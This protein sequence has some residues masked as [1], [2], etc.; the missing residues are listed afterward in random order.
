MSL[1]DEVKTNL[2]DLYNVTSHKTV[3]V[4]R[5]SSRKYEK[6]GISR[7]IE[8]QFSELGSLVFNSVQE[9]RSEEIAG[10]EQILALV[11]RIAVLEKELKE[12]DEEIDNIRQEATRPPRE[13]AAAAGSAEDFSAENDG[14]PETAGSVDTII[15]DPILQEGREESAILMDA[16]EV[17]DILY[18]SE[19]DDVTDEQ[20]VRDNP[21]NEG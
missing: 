20:Q 17:E 7:D 10:D 15:T 1:W 16:G 6:F 11:A 5:I 4:A 12:K 3:E 21:Q 9:D 8:R 2:F 19:A 14:E 13:K 18:E